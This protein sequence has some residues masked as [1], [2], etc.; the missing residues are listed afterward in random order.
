MS[1]WIE[2]LLEGVAD[3]ERRVV[4]RYTDGLL[5]LARQQLPDRFRGRVDAE[6]IVQSVYRSFFGRLRD[7]QFKFE[8]SHDLWRLLIVMTYHKVS[9]T[10]KHHLRHRRDL[11]RERTP[12]ADEALPQPEPGPEDL[13]VLQDLLAN[14]LEG[15]PD[16]YQRMVTLRLEGFSLEEIAAR[17]NL[18]RRTIIRVLNKVE[19]SAVE[20]LELA[21]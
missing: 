7:G 17:V 1:V 4:D 13:A 18:S 11:R 14:M 16:A 19:A 3:A 12:A 9:N 8:D 15:L 21:P 2:G 5:K 10:I 6:D 20:R